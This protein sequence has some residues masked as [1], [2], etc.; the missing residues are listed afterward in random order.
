MTPEKSASQHTP[1][2]SSHT[3]SNKKVEYP[4]SPLK[5]N[6]HIKDHGDYEGTKHTTNKSWDTQLKAATDEHSYG[7]SGTLEQSYYQNPS[8]SVLH[9]SYSSIAHQENPRNQDTEMDIDVSESH[10]SGKV[11][12]QSPD[13][14]PTTQNGG[15]FV[16]TNI[17]ELSLP[18]TNINLASAPGSPDRK[19]NVEEAPCSRTRAIRSTD[20]DILHAS[21]GP[22][23]DA[24][25]FIW[26]NKRPTD[27]FIQSLIPTEPPL[28]NW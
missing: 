27:A 24:P 6:Q 8:D 17:D 5:P 9:C 15:N 14:G 7:L 22:S 2:L 26:E 16:D 12:T 25:D 20:G 21:A 28:N 18:I 11:S 4:L 19:M 13:R 10:K 1:S 23:Y 3:T